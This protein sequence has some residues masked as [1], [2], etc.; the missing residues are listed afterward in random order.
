MHHVE[1]QQRGHAVIAE[2]L[3]A[4]GEGEIGDPARVAKKAVST[5]ETLNHQSF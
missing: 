2:P 1:R 4:F 3:P 5:I